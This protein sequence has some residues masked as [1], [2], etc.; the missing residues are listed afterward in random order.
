MD[1]R[2]GKREYDPEIGTDVPASEENFSLEEI[3]AEYGGGRQKLLR[4]VEELVA[5]QTAPEAPPRPQEPDEIGT[6]LFHRQESPAE[7]PPVPSA[8][9]ETPAPPSHRA[10]A[11]TDN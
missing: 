3:L 7:R 10:G 11:A 4:E 6:P 1:Q 8:P 5:R 9:P 2:Q